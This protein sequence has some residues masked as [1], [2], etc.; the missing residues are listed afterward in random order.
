MPAFTHAL[1]LRGGRV[2][3]S[4]PMG[5]VV[6]TARLS[7]AFGSRITIRRKAGRFFASAAHRARPHL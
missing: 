1:L 2:Y 7:G 6:T 5:R 4:G 3:A